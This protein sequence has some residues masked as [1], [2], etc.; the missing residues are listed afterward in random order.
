MFNAKMRFLSTVCFANACLSVSLALPAEPTDRD[1]PRTKQRLQIRVFNL[2]HVREHDLVRT[3]AEIGRIFDM[4]DIDARW[5]EGS[6]DDRSALVTDFS[7]NHSSHGRCK[8]AVNASELRVQLLTRAPPGVAGGTLA[9]SLPCARFG[10][11]STIFIEQCEAVTHYTII[12]F[13]KVLAYVIAHELGH[14]L[15][16]SSEHSGSGLMRAYW[17]R[18]AWISA[19]AGGI[20]I[21]LEQARRMRIELFRMESLAPTEPSR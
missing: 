1:S 18:N 7:A 8:D 9:Y 3:E 4:A 12:A 6:P 11:H 19:A 21:D 17:D 14:V 20:R 10:I 2:A 15:L 13:S 16:R 5:A